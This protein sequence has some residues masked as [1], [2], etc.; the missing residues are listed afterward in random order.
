M[1]EE[2]L[3]QAEQEILDDKKKDIREKIKS[4]LIEKE[5]LTNRIVTI[6]KELNELVLSGEVKNIENYIKIGTKPIDT[7]I[8]INPF[9]CEATNLTC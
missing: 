5:K 6:D 2:Q 9:L 7:G 1:Y 8:T 3:K 4:R